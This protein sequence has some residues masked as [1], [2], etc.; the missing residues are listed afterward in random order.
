M[1]KSLHAD[2]YSVDSIYFAAYMALA[3]FILMLH[4]YHSVLFWFSRGLS[5]LGY[6]SIKHVFL[7]FL[8]YSRLNYQFPGLANLSPLQ[9][10]ICL[11]YFIGNIACNLVD[12]HSLQDEATR[13]A[14]LSLINMWPLFFSGGRE[15][16]A[17]IL[18]M[19]QKTYGI[20]HCLAGLLVTIQASIHVAIT[21]QMVPF[22]TEDDNQYYGLLVGRLLF[23]FFTLT[24]L[25]SRHSNY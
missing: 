22:T 10:I 1:P 4:V 20:I 13:A 9:L 25:S 15:F 23:G 16:G 3:A 24:K 8:V 12:V 19:S 11:A 14:H 21:C 5:C 18:G 2:M 6:A 7:R 17:R